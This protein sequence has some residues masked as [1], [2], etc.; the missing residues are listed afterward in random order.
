[1]CRYDLQ[2]VAVQP[3]APKHWQPLEAGWVNRLY[4]V[5]VKISVTNTGE[6]WRHYT[7]LNTL[8]SSGLRQKIIQYNMQL[9]RGK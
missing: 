7:R 1:M 5:L 2:F 6:T 4:G 3:Q 9:G 8:Q